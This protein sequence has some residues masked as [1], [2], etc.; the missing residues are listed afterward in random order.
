MSDLFSDAQAAV[1][2]GNLEEA[3]VLLAKLL[4][5]DRRNAAA[6]YLLST[7]V[8]SAEQ[9]EIFLRRVLK[10]DP[11]HAAA[12]ARMGELE[13]V[14]LAASPAGMPAQETPTPAS[15]AMPISQ[16][17]DDF[18]AQ[19]AGDTLPPW[20]AD[21]GDMVLEPTATTEP[22]APAPTPAA[23]MEIPDWLQE[24]PASDWEKEREEAVA[25][26]RAAAQPVPSPKPSPKQQ[27]TKRA[28]SS[29]TLLTVLV[30]AAI[31]VFIILVYLLITIGPSL[32]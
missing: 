5:E 31:L 23:A 24:M 7:I 10:I 30:V 15:I 32:F 11:T 18:E 4:K 8:P 20:L 1:N 13:G 28:G 3:H 14:I 22:T 26:A 9:E 16:D 25:A 2:A 29:S 21:D 27:P 6:W 17:A 19:A 12:T